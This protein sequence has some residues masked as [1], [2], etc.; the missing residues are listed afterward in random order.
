MTR[1]TLIENG[2]LK[3]KQTFVV[4]SRTLNTL[5]YLKT[6]AGYLKFNIDIIEDGIKESA[7]PK[8]DIKRFLATI[9]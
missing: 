3:T 7:T 2:T 4:S 5:E 1:I 8:K 6:A 9:N